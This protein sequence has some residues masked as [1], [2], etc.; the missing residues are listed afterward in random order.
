MMCK[1]A[2][3]DVD[4]SQPVHLSMF[5]VD[6]K[7]TRHLSAAQAGLT[8]ADLS[9]LELAWAIGFPD[10]GGLRA[11]PVIIGSTLFYHGIQNELLGMDTQSACVKWVY[12]AGAALRTSIAY[13]DLG[14]SGR[15]ALIVADHR[16]FVH[17]IDARTGVGI[18]ATEAKHTARAG[19]TGSPVL[20]RDKVIVPISASG[21]GRAANPRVRVLCGARGGGGPGRAHGPQAL[22]P[23]HHG[24]GHLHGPGQPRRKEAAGS[25]RCRGLVHPD[26]G[27]RTRPGL[28]DHRPEHVTARDGYQRC[29]P[30]SRCTNGRA[31]VG[32][33]GPGPRR[34]EC[35]LSRSLG[36]LRSE[37]SE[38][39][40]ERA[41]GPRLR[42]LG[43]HRQARRRQGHPPGRPE[44]GGCLG[45]GS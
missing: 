29:D 42:R 19:I 20:W 24:R 38:S 23:S 43:H 5:G 30:G 2:E 12:D 4:L 32:L 15:M 45:P 14:H 18:W 34:V 36:E 37:L 39:G 33:P 25:L 17:A 40:G 35:C 31:R 22:D 13:G 6:H 27:C 21:V 41:Q 9:D 16:G 3:R 8:S 28:R 44:V 7:S 11:S 1:E 10:I 26:R